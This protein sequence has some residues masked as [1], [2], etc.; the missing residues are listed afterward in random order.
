ML[1]NSYVLVE[2]LT[3]KFL[4]T[5]TN[6]TNTKAFGP[7]SEKKISTGTVL[8]MV[9]AGLG[10]DHVPDRRRQFELQYYWAVL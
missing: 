7:S 5:D 6:S 10:Q 2:L 9:H 8:G 4:L 1:D 3:F